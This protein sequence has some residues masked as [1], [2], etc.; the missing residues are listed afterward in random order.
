MTAPAPRE[1][2]ARQ[3]TLDEVSLPSRFTPIQILGTGAMGYVVEARDLTL[4]RDVAVKVISS[5]RLNDARSRDRFLREAR[6]IAA[7]RHANIVTVFDLDPAG[8]FLVMELIRGETLKQRLERA[9]VLPADEVRR[10]GAALLSALAAAHEAGIVHRDVKPA[11]ILLGGDGSIKLADFGVA[12]TTDSELTGTGEVIG[13]PAYMAPEQLRGLE[14]DLRVDIYAAGATLFEAATGSRLHRSPNARAEDVQNTIMSAVPDT[15]LATA[16]CRAVSERPLDRYEDARGFAEAVSAIPRPALVPRWARVSAGVFVL[17]A[18]ILTL[19]MWRSSNH[20]DPSASPVMEQ[21]VTSVALGV[22]AL[23]RQ[24][25]AAAER[26]LRA[27]DQNLPEVHYYLGILYWWTSRGA[28]A[29]LDKALAGGLDERMT[30]IAKAIR[31]V[32]NLEY[33]TV[34][35]TFREL[36]KRYPRDREVLYGLFESLFHGGRPNESIQVY[37][38]LRQVAPS[39]GLGHYHVLTYWL[40]RGDLDNARWAAQSAGKE[41]ALWQA[42]VY[43]AAGQYDA[44]LQLLERQPGEANPHILERASIHARAGELTRAHELLETLDMRRGANALLALSN[45]RGTAFGAEAITYLW[46]VVIA[47]ADVPPSISASTRESWTE[48]APFVAIDGDPERAE[49]V[50]GGLSRKLDDRWIEVGLARAM[51]SAITQD[52]HELAHLIEVT[53]FPEV[54][55]VATAS[56]AELEG[57][58]RR[59]ADA[60]K[61]ALDTEGMG[62]FRI[63]ET[64]YWARALHKAGDPLAIDACDR[65]IQPGMFHWSW[66]LAVGECLH[67]TA[68]AHRQAG[69]VEQSHEASRRL[70]K[71]RD[72]APA[73]DPLVRAARANL[74]L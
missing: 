51:L 16:I 44:A 35:D 66:G 61:R 27:A 7:L 20:A 11:N 9:K 49:K 60:W 58:H 31:S 46:K 48:L 4:N 2:V 17:A 41:L 29:E 3:P 52:R 24:D 73:D 54:R 40:S 53:P 28:I 36:D 69:R 63:A 8:K 13:T 65:V 72:D 74:G 64:L 25:F 45:A 14:T 70:L 55:E 30:A 22:E 37:R 15:G 71:L 19:F 23:G 50:L 39:F 1:S 67:I 38:Q 68:E 12:A 10:I 42:R 26:H 59:A 21:E 34:I 56:V 47:A 32:V 5:K 57:D 43:V 62:R 33:P 6:T 18:A